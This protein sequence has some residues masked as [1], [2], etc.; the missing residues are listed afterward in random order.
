ME[1]TTPMKILRITTVLF[2]LVMGSA[3]ADE[4]AIINARIV[5]MDDE[6]PAASTLLIS[7]NRIVSV[8]SSDPEAGDYPDEVT[9]IN[10]EGAVVIPGIIDQ[11]LHW[12]RS[13]ITWGYALHRGENA[14]T[15]QALQDALQARAEEVPAGEWITLIGRH[16][17]RQFLEDPS[18]PD[19]AAGI[20]L[21]RS[22]TSG[23]PSTTFSFR[24]G[25]DRH[26]PDRGPTTS[27]A[28]ASRVPAR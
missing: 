25:S 28:P 24:R 10:A 20:R 21:V 6:N 23:F 15:L 27:I 26:R 13:A 4:I 16:N 12:N 22:W 5:T 14:F 18:D 8:D 1:I 11:H 2:S 7:E 17:H 9:V 19:S 3:H